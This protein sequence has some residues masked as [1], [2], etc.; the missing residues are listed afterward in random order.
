M[1]G[2]SG[3]E[4]LGNLKALSFMGRNNSQIALRAAV[5]SAA[6]I[7]AVTLSVP[8]RAG[9]DNSGSSFYKATF[10]RVLESFGLK[11]ADDNSSINYQERPPLVLPPDRTLPPPEKTDVVNN[12]AWPKDPDV[13]RRKLVAERDKNRNVSDER[14]REQNPLRPDELTPGPRPGGAK[15]V[16][17]GDP[18]RKD[19]ISDFGAI[20]S[21][22]E[23]GY[24]GGLFSKMFHGK[25]DDVAQFTGEPPRKDLTEPPVGY[26]T[27][28]PNQ[29]YGLGAETVRSKP[30]NYY[31]SH[32]ELNSG[33]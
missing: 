16:A 9:D 10:G 22:S 6:A 19:P 27:P 33:R 11:S 25:D 4:F 24:K 18:S 26:Q 7:A 30:D 20:L 1:T 29:P 12:P 15:G 5:F 13:K 17:L 31:E 28:S 21:P 14:E 2:A 23:L 3:H 32:G 8:A